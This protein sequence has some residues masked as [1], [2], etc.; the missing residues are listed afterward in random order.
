MIVVGGGNS[1]FQE[2]LFLTRFASKVTI[3]EITDRINASA[4]LQEQVERQPNMEVRTRTAI[5]GFRGD[6]AYAR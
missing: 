3:L 5:Q 4:I 6:T 1:G 2:S